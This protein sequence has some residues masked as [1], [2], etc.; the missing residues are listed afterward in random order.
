MTT[1]EDANKDTARWS[2]KEIIV[3]SSRKSEDALARDDEST[4]WETRPTN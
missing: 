2:N 1:D 4:R 3:G